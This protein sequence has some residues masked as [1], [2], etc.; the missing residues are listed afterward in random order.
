MIAQERL[1]SKKDMGQRSKMKNIIPVLLS[2]AILSGCA[3]ADRG[4]SADVL[5]T[6][7]A[8]QQGFSEGNPIMAHL[9]IPQMAAVKLGLTQAVKFLPE[10]YCTNGLWGLTAA[11]YGAA[12][13]N[14]GVMLGSGP[15]AIP[16]IIGLV[17]WQW[18]DWAFSSN[19][20]C[21]DPWHFEPPTFLPVSHNDMN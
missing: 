6:Y 4:Q 5:S 18:D 16:F 19:R 1:K 3:T 15:A 17:W 10:P 14:T 12:I 21:L 11:G 13:W 20:T 8:F 7:V 9:T 2:A